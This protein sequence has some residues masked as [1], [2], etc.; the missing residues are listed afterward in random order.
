LLE[1]YQAALVNDPTYRSAFF[2]SEAGKEYKNLGLSA[3]LPS[4]TGTYQ[5]NK[6]KADLTADT[7]LGEQTSHPQ[8]IS[9]IQQIQLRQV[10]FSL[11]ALARYK[12]GVAQAKFSEAQFSSQGQDLVVRLTAAYLEAALGAEQ[13]RLA[14]AQRDAQRE[15]MSSNDKM[16]QKGEGT[17]TDM[18]E[19]Q[20]R[21]ELSEA[22]VLEAKDTRQVNINVLEEL[23]GEPVT[24]L[25]ELGDTF[26]MAPMLESFDDWKGIAL[27]NS[28][29]LEAQRFSIEASRQEV[30]KN[31]A[32]HTP[33][34]DFVSSYSK[35]T[36]ETLNTY[37]QDSTN[38]SV[39]VQ[40]NIPIYSGGA[41]SAATR[42][43]VANF[44]KAKSD[45][46]LKTGKLLVELRK[47]YTTVVSS[48]A[49]IA[50]LDKALASAKLL[51]TATEQSIKGGVRVNLDLLNAQQ[52]FFTTQRDL[53]Q[54]RYTYLISL[55][56]LRAA[57]GVLGSD[58][59]RETSNYFH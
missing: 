11:D 41:V 40:I 31:R 19:T 35:N 48:A 6:N 43:S 12:Q 14:E 58:D 52:Q 53:T 54:A 17:R 50:A 46:D 56:R 2:D 1:A 57:A 15:Q 33:R 30:N 32:G 16:F 37:N 42:Q 45:L 34:V 23:I 47:Q 44:E 10:L 7:I 21:L 18:L 59:V 29:D 13:V 39:G 28:P 49:K 20:A 8:Y 38:R 27:K 36:A 4:I 55:L 9:R 5:F 22:Q 24:A 25:G 26:R 3:L 51:I